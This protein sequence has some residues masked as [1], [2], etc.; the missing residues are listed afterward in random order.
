MTSTALVCY[1]I[2]IVF[3]GIKEVFSKVCYAAEYTKI[4]LIISISS[5]IINIIL[6]YLFALIWGYAGIALSTSISFAINCILII[7]MVMRKKLVVI[8]FKTV[9]RVFLILSYSFFIF[10]IFLFLKV[11]ILNYIGFLLLRVISGVIIIF[12]SY[13]A[14]GYFMGNKTLLRGKN[15]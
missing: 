4:P 10:I 14:V 12:G 1:S 2:G 9:K 15:W 6:N 13:F 11:F 7:I 3:W 5:M 8:E